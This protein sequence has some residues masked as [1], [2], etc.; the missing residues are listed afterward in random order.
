MSLKGEFNSWRNTVDPEAE[1]ARRQA[2]SAIPID[3]IR[4]MA[5]LPLIP[6]QQLPRPTTELCTTPKIPPERTIPREQPSAHERA[7]PSDLLL[8]S[9]YPSRNPLSPT[10]PKFKKVLEILSL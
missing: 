5:L 10:S 1:Q 7:L 8:R 2:F 6:P 9:R 4:E 3:K